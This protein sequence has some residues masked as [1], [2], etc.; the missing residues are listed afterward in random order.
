MEGFDPN[1]Q[2]KIGVLLTNLGTP[3]NPTKKSLRKYLKEFLSDV[4]VVDYNRVLWFLILHGIIL[5]VRPKR[6]AKLYKKIWM[7]KGSPLMVYMNEIVE[8]LKI[9]M[10]QKNLM[11]ELGMRYG[12]PSIENALSLIHI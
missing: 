8:K 5:N 4:R 10:D 3:D 2:N 11:V 1:Y 7:E 9:V 6:S 12:N